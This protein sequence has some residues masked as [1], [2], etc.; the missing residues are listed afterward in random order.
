MRAKSLR[1]TCGAC[2]RRSLLA[3]R[4][5]AGRM[6]AFNA[7]SIMH[8]HHHQ[9]H[10][11]APLHVAKHT[12][13]HS[14]FLRTPLFSKRSSRSCVQVE[15]HQLR[16]QLAACSCCARR[17]SGTNYARSEGPSTTSYVSIRQHT[18]AYVR[19]RPFARHQL[20]L[21]LAVAVRGS[22]GGSALAPTAHVSTSEGAASSSWHSSA[23]QLRAVQHASAYATYA[24]VC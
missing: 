1:Y 7:S 21:Q 6:H 23:A 3:G 12:H 22:G 14:L 13:T 11:K 16:L 15:R 20:R 10:H 8:H 9:Q 18:S 4:M 2:H 24:D 17:R 5:L 19:I